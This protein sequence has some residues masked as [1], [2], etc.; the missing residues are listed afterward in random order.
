[1]LIP[2]IAVAADAPATLAVMPALATA[3]AGFGDL[4]FARMRERRATV[5]ADLDAR[6]AEGRRLLAHDLLEHPT[7]GHLAAAS[8]ILRSA[9]DRMSPGDPSA[10]DFHAIDGA[11]TTVDR[12]ERT[13]RDTGP[14]R[15]ARRHNG[16]RL[17]RS[18]LSARRDG[19][20][21]IQPLTVHSVITDV[22]GLHS[23]EIE[24]SVLVFTLWARL[25]LVM[26]AP[27]LASVSFGDAPLENGWSLDDLPWLLA[28]V[29]SLATALLAPWIATTAMRGDRRGATLRGLLVTVEAPLAVVTILATPCWP[30]ATFAAGWTNWWQRPSFNVPRLVTWAAIVVTAL[31]TGMAFHGLPVPAIAAETGTALVVMG[32]IGGSYGAMFPLTIGVVVRNVVGGLISRR[33][34]RRT[35]GRQLGDAVSELLIAAEVIERKA[36]VA[37]IIAECDAVSLRDIADE[38]AQGS[39]R[40]DRRTM[41]APLGL[42]ALLDAALERC[43]PM[44]GTPAAGRLMA[45]AKL[46]GS[47]APLTAL[48]S[49]FYGA[50]LYRRRFRRRGQAHALSDLIG[51]IVREARRY[52]TGP[53]LTRC[54]EQDGRIVIR[55]ANVVLPQPPPSGRGTGL[56]RLE[57]L[58]ARIPG[59]S[60][61]IRQVVDGT[62]VDLPAAARRFGVQVSL[63]S[64][65]LLNMDDR[66]GHRP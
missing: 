18:A 39:D 42:E 53:L 36:P 41:Q 8:A 33:Q 7:H 54:H 57:R 50:T 4:T 66:R 14:I 51:E 12:L 43:C 11:L 64:S 63:P 17:G 16:R 26:L 2:A 65:L 34:A 58:A 23:A 25:L 30:V 38:L 47:P 13:I 40:R 60:L 35:A 5:K 15:R 46:T 1:L 24:W 37:D 44:T 3:V 52:G 27:L 56:A 9:R 20:R 55:L 61:D 10:A 48:P 22:R 21:P 62:F 31:A 29:W 59:G 6:F 19:H 45:Q 32:A 49:S 28:A